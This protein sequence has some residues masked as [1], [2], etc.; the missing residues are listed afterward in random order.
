MTSIK[1][2]RFEDV[3]TE[4]QRARRRS[5]E[6]RKEWKERPPSEDRINAFRSIQDDLER[7]IVDLRVWDHERSAY[8]RDAKRE[9]GDCLGVK[10][11]TYRDAGDYP[12]A[13]EA[14]DDGL[15]YERAVNQLGGHPNS[16][17]LVQR[18]VTRVLAEPEAFSRSEPIQGVDVHAELAQCVETLRNQMAVVRSGDPWAQ[19]DLAVV[20]QLLATGPIA[21]PR[22]ADAAT[23]WDQ[24]DD[25]RP[26]RFVY[27][28]TREVVQLLRQRLE[29][30]SLST[31]AAWSDVV[32]RLSAG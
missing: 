10:G 20:M 14:Y 30:L 21:S 28:S 2:S 29:H 12:R 13:A 15:D 19:A 16:Y 6:V 23:A 32:S 1:T 26:D 5:K 9:I 4:A 7:V 18:L 8:R 11:G 24:L 31:K 3:A 22:A 25:M 17:C 27:G